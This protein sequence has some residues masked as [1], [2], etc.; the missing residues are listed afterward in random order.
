MQQLDVLAR[1]LGLDEELA[2][3]DV[4][5]ATQLLSNTGTVLPEKLW[6]HC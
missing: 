6:P 3:G 2:Q 1:E 4:Q 5:A